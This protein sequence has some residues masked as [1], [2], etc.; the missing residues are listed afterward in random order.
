MAAY[1]RRT[2]LSV[3][4][5]LPLLSDATNRELV[6]LRPPSR[7]AVAEALCPR[8]DRFV[9]LDRGPVPPAIVLRT[10]QIKPADRRPVIKEHVQLGFGGKTPVLVAMGIELFSV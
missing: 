8:V 6:V 2:S 5:G 3:P 9:G 1:P 4:A 7:L 10:V